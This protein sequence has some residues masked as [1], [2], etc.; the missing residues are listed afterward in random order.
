MIRYDGRADALHIHL[1]DGAVQSQRELRPGVILHLGAHEKFLGLEI[2]EA[3][4]H[5]A[6]KDLGRL[7]LGEC[8]YRGACKAVLEFPKAVNRAD[9][10]QLI[11]A[12][13]ADGWEVAPARRRVQAEA[14]L[15]AS[16]PKALL[17]VRR[18][19]PA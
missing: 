13:Q 2:R 10:E 7:V 17:F 14:A 9:Y 11:A 18:K 12:T 19:Q 4:R 6:L 8:A 3:S 16:A 5:I 15:A 1:G